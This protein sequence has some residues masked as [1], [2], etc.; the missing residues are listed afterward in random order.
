MFVLSNAPQDTNLKFRRVP[1]VPVAYVETRWHKGSHETTL[2]GRSRF[3]HVLV[4]KGS[5]E[6]KS[7]KRYEDSGGSLQ[8]TMPQ[9]D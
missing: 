5:N 4:E 9:V 3:T 7:C 8:H 6:A 1:I 2:R